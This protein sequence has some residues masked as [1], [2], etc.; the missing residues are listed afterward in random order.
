MWWGIVCQALE[1]GAHSIAVSLNGVSL[2]GC[3][4]LVHVRDPDGMRGLITLPVH[5]LSSAQLNLSPVV[6]SSWPR[7]THCGAVSTFNSRTEGLKC[8]ETLLDGE[9]INLGN[10]APAG[11]PKD[12][13]FLVGWRKVN[14][15]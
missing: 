12:K 14:P 10:K 11:A 13:K 9:E 8:K 3:P 1:S 5:F 15:A 7:L 6:A 4:F 2:P